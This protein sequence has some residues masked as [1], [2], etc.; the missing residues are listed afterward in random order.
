MNEQTNGKIQKINYTIYERT[1]E[2]TKKRSNDRTNE[3][4]K[5]QSNERTNERTDKGMNERTIERM[6]E[7]TYFCSLV[8]SF[9]LLA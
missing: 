6:N 9:L 3:R 8:A 2:R 7:R 4:T 1:N 5:K